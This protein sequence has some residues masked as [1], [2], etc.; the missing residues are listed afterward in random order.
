MIK[1]KEVKI[2]PIDELKHKFIKAELI[3]ILEDSLNK[4]L[5]EIDIKGDFERT[6]NNPKI[7]A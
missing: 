5:G 7:T 6:I 1:P 4:T 2:V 3:R